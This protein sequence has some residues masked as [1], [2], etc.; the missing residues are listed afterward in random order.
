MLIDI[1]IRTVK[2][3]QA[4]KR[5]VVGEIARAEPMENEF[6]W[7]KLLSREGNL[8]PLLI[9][10]SSR[11]KAVVA[12]VAP[13]SRVRV[14]FIASALYHRVRRSVGRE[15]TDISRFPGR[16]AAA[17]T[18][19]AR[20]ACVCHVRATRWE[21]R[22]SF[23]ERGRREPRET[24][25]SREDEAKRDQPDQ[26]PPPGGV[27][28]VP[29]R[30]GVPLRAFAAQPS[31]FDDARHPGGGGGR[32]RPEGWRQ[33]RDRRAFTSGTNGKPSAGLRSESNSPSWSRGKMDVTRVD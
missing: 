24:W 8:P 7:T 2:F 13:V 11:G 26:V 27:H 28:R 6:S 21:V 15:P 29:D 4:A 31:D 20:S 33:S 12:P 3:A 14:R 18:D 19:D 23:R 25:S 5:W 9:Y 1:C 32:R 17:M 10:Q 16:R 22:L 30:R